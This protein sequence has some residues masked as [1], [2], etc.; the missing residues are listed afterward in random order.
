VHVPADVG[1]EGE[2]VREEEGAEQEVQDASIRRKLKSFESSFALVPAISML[3]LAAIPEK[4]ICPS[5]G[6]KP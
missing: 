1:A 5:S 6:S 2:E 3:K 4:S